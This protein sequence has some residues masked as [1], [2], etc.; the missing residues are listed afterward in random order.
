MGTRPRFDHYGRLA[1]ATLTPL[2]ELGRPRVDV[3]MT[4]SGIFRD[5]LPLQIR[6]LVEAALLAAKADEPE[7]KNFIRKHALAYQQSHGGDME[8]AALR[9]FGNAEGTYGA[10]VSQLIDCSRW[11]DEDELAETYTCRK[12]FAYSASGRPVARPDLLNTLLARMDLAYQNLDSVEVGVTTTDTYFE[13]LGGISRAVKR[14]KGPDAKIA[15][16]YIGGQTRGG[17]A[18]RTLSEQV[19]LETRTRML[20]PKWYEGMLAH[21]YEGVH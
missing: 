15:P 18:V 13:T 5:L 20:N 10:N 19:A 6:M 9:V 12:G 7:D 14:A 4:L 8:T 3:L 2:E 17:G 11:D 21:G 16:V 1:G